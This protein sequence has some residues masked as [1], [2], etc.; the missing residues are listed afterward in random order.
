LSR[1]RDFWYFLVYFSFIFLF[2]HKLLFSQQF[3]TF[4]DWYIPRQD[5]NYLLYAWDEELFGHVNLFRSVDGLF[6]FLSFTFGM[7]PAQKFL[8]T[9]IFLLPYLSFY[10]LLRK[11]FGLPST[12]SFLAA[13]LY[14]FNPVTLDFLW[15]GSGAYTGV[16][17][18]GSIPLI[19]YFIRNFSR[20]DFFTI[21]LFSFIT[22]FVSYN[23][24]MF[25]LLLIPLL[26]FH[27]LTSYINKMSF[28]FSGVLRKVFFIIILSSLL[29][30]SNLSFTLSRI[31]SLQ[32]QDFFQNL[33]ISNLKWSYGNISY[34]NL[35][36]LNF[37]PSNYFVYHNYYLD[38]CDFDIFYLAI[39]FL[40][41]LCFIFNNNKNERYYVQ[42]LI[43]IFISVILLE[44]ILII[45]LIINNGLYVKELLLILSLVRNPD[46]IL[47]SL[48]F[49]ISLSFGF[50]VNTIFPK[51]A[52]TIRGAKILSFSVIFIFLVALCFSYMPVW[53]GYGG[54]TR[55]YYENVDSNLNLLTI[56]KEEKLPELLN[57]FNLTNERILYLPYSSPAL[58]T[59]GDQKK[60]LPFVPNV[61]GI[62]QGGILD[63]YNSKLI[64]AIHDFYSSI[65]KMELRKIE[66]YLDFFSINYVIIA[67]NSY[68][69][70]MR[71][72]TM[73]ASKVPYIYGS[74]IE[75]FK[76]FKDLNCSI[77]CENE[78]YVILKK[79]TESLPL[80][81]GLSYK[82]E[83]VSNL[84]DINERCQMINSTH[85][86]CSDD[87][88]KINNSFQEGFNA[89][90]NFNLNKGGQENWHS[91]SFYLFK[92]WKN[93]IRINFL[94]KGGMSVGKATNG[95]WTPY[96]TFITTP[97]IV[98]GQS[99]EIE[100]LKL[101]GLL[102]IKYHNNKL[103]YVDSTMQE[104]PYILLQ[105]E[106]SEGYLTKPTLYSIDLIK[107]NYTKITPVK[108][109]I[110]TTEDITYI[111]FSHNY[112]GNWAIIHQNE[113]IKSDCSFL[114]LNL[115][116]ISNVNKIPLNLYYQPQDLFISFKTIS[117][118]TFIIIGYLII[119]LFIKKRKRL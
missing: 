26:L 111:N 24:V 29:S 73:G 90:L 35:L 5:V 64:Y 92:D 8:F 34:T 59:A 85:F 97:P 102:E 36:L 18:Y 13:V 82:H 17:V 1:K 6:L 10:F 104:L 108:Y 106:K 119:V 61:V 80:I 32:E 58:F 86:F 31:T 109:L 54:F 87:V 63:G 99:Y 42:F 28:D 115:F 91:F 41:F 75:F 4:K 65:A 107:V 60:L 100:V 95:S 101:R 15:G 14:S 110:Q 72:T 43:S 39:W 78:D 23:L 89:F 53:D 96:K 45:S 30:L 16:T 112:N 98:N 19:Y 76:V 83:N 103:I 25:L 9:F 3:F 33:I 93:F 46:K 70:T 12:P 71:V 77:V 27:F 84:I 40:I 22:S 38:G 81:Y 11:G 88:F 49:F 44:S 105:F 56:S 113:K 67:K 116:T 7:L 62:R 69:V 2:L 50:A 66:A 79:P 51:I 68:N 94:Q 114:G 20:A 37:N 21:V 48:L 52:K 118:L 47:A 117:V 55:Y 57:Y 74:Y